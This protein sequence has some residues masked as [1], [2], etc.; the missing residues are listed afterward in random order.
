MTRIVQGATLPLTQCLAWVFKIKGFNLAHNKYKGEDEI[1]DI[2]FG[3]KPA[4]TGQET[5]FL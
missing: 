4:H 1:G 5:S 2:Y 3:S